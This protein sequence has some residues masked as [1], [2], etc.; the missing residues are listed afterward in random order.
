MSIDG[1][2]RTVLITSF[3]VALIIGAGGA[4]FVLHQR[5][6]R[7]T[8][9]EAG[10]LLTVATAVRTYTTRDVEPAVAKD[11]KTFRAVT[12]PAFGAQSVFRT[13]Q[14]SNSGYVY[15]EPALN[16]TNPHDLP[17]PFEVDLIN[18][19][20]ADTGLKELAG[21]RKDG[22]GSV[23]Y[24]ARPIRA[25]PVCLT[26]HDTPERAPAAMVAKYGPHNGFGWNRDEV[27]AIQSLTVPAAAESRETGEI[28]MILAGGLL[29][30]FVVTYFALTWAIDSLLVRPLRSLALAADAA[31]TGGDVNVAVAA[32]GAHE[33][34]EVAVS[35]ERLRT[36]LNKSLQ[37]LAKVGP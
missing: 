4:Y 33:I 24:L 12:V 19:F 28:A 23:Y 14:Q 9:A 36:S 26:C 3:I 11:D 35:I 6:V 29:L 34:H 7:H 37:R 17:T 2:V 8:A 10:R 16:P 22:E 30:V 32:S 20:R 5:A 25:Q 18:K 15:R 27:V 1:V 13:A 31:S 21:V